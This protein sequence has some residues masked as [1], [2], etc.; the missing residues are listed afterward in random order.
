M[1]NKKAKKIKKEVYGEDST[2]SGILS[3]ITKTIIKKLKGK[4]VKEEY[5]GKTVKMNFGCLEADPKRQEYQRLKKEYNNLT[6]KERGAI[7]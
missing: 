5:R 4:R 2:R 7:I 1:N 3:S 6:R